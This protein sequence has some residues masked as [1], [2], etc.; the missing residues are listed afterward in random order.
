[1]LNL[2]GTKPEGEGPVTCN[3]K[4]ER[5]RNIR[6]SDTVGA[7]SDHDLQSTSTHH[8]LPSAH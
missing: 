7:V 4:L 8:V 2:N 5:F 3:V 6:Q 1:M